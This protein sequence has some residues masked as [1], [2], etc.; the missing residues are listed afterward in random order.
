ME[1]AAVKTIKSLQIG[2][3]WLPEEEQGN[4]LDRVFYALTR[5]LPEAGVDVR[6][7]VVGSDNVVHDSKQTVQSF[8][9]KDESLRRRI[10]ALRSTIREE[11]RTQD[12]DLVASHFALF[13]Y[14]ILKFIRDYPLVMHFHGPW[15][16]ES[17]AEGEGKLAVKAKWALERTVYK[18]ADR[19]IVLSD[20]FRDLLIQHYKIDGRLIRKVPGGVHVDRFDTGRSLVE[21]R[22]QLGWPT[23]RP[24]V[25]VIR[26]L[27]R[28]MGLENLIAAMVQVRQKNPDVLLHIAG[29]GPIRSELEDRIQIADLQDHVKLLGFVP[30]EDLPLAY[31]GANFS[32]VPTVSL[33]GFGLITIE[34][35]A[36]GTPVLVTNI[37]GL[38]ETV[39]DLSEDLII[40]DSEVKTL[41]TYIMNALSGQLQLP[42]C[43][44]CQAYVRE[45]FDWPVIARQVRE[46][47]EE[48]IS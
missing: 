20:A 38:P 1:L 41:A 48:V 33:E 12:Y 18:S 31:R 40:P 24:I 35:M 39:K 32:I 5:N 6:G 14:P 25:F 10:G 22:E 28:R 29:S 7:L 2:V 36:A 34:S 9:T 45:R 44:A 27:A 8:A 16:A 43:E 47:Y 46:V 15:S 4:G 17:R 30:D 23:D 37:G 3:G 19:F 26:R 13:T 21:A 42:S 11:L